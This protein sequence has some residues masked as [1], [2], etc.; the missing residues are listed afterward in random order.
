MDDSN[1]KPTIEY[2]KKPDGKKV[3][4]DKANESFELGFYEHQLIEEFIDAY[5]RK[6]GLPPIVNF[7][8]YPLRVDSEDPYEGREDAM[9]TLSAGFLIVIPKPK[10]SD[11]TSK[12]IYFRIRS[13]MRNM[14]LA[15]KAFLSIRNHPRLKDIEPAIEEKL[16]STDEAD[17][18]PF[19]R[20][21]Y[22]EIQ[23]MERQDV[24]RCRWF[25]QLLEDLEVEGTEPKCEENGDE[26]V[27]CDTLE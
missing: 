14:D 3:G 16:P 2:L 6:K 9:K 24:Y 12:L 10:D 23:M 19:R 17:K 27:N 26:Q 18:A 15:R 25:S 20:R 13:S 4:W 22:H 1:K 5:V 7:E 21:A 11:D 8:V